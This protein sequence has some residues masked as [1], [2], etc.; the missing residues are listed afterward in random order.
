MFVPVPFL[1]KLLLV[2]L[3]WLTAH[4]ASARDTLSVT[5]AMPNTALQSWLVGLEDH[6]RQ[7][8]PVQV[9]AGRD[10]MAPV[11]D[12]LQLEPT[13]H[14]W[15][16]IPLRNTTDSAVAPILHFSSLTF[17]DAWLFVGD[18]LVLHRAAGAFRP[19][20]ELAPGDGRFHLSLPMQAGQQYNLLLK[21]WHTKH[22]HPT[23]DFA[24]QSPLVYQQEHAR[25]ERLDA[26]AQGAMGIFLLYTLL[27][28]L[29]SR[30]RP[31]LWLT[32]FIAGVALYGLS[33]GPYMID[34]FY[35]DNP[36]TGWVFNVLYLHLAQLGM[37]LLVIDFWSLRQFNPRLYRM[38]LGFATVLPVLSVASFS[39]NYFT[40]NYNLMNNINLLAFLLPFSFVLLA[41]RVCWRRLDRA[42]RFLCYG[43]LLF[44]LGALLISGG[45][46]FLREKALDFTPYIGH[47]ATLSIF[48]LFS[49]GLKEKQRQHELDRNAAL[50]ELNRLQHEQNLLLEKKVTERTLDLQQSNGQLR[51]QWDELGRRNAQIET[52]INE[53]SHR[54]K[55]NLQLLYSLNSLQLPLVQ[56]AAAQHVLRGNIARIRAMMLVNQKLYRPEADTAIPVEESVRELT[57]HLQQIYDAAHKV[58]IR[59][60]IQADG[61]LAPKQLLSLAMILAELLTNS[62]KY[63]FGEIGEP[64][65]DI[66]IRL[67]RDQLQVLY[68]DNGVGLPLDRTNSSSMGLPLVRDLVRQLQGSMEVRNE[69][70]LAYHFRI[71]M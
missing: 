52:L 40:G 44:V 13:N 48:I 29:V 32:F 64:V 66:R 24:L 53:L 36:A 5:P 21:V 60:D 4:M 10:H 28:W 26:W 15:L 39:I 47:I 41:I 69:G 38:G 65:I 42:Q 67:E 35:P 58:S 2:T 37:Y 50:A 68:A 55:N 63:A 12:L 1:R 46:F 71:P 45:S 62:F 34:W 17:V 56:D 22:Y 27:S 3:C 31:Y 18:S 57:G 30:F 7:L 19:A 33:T 8:T 51:M 11:H 14:Y 61:V 9:L 54:V 70:G 43:M 25:R 49:T 20:A 16:Y 23:F 6:S 59:Q